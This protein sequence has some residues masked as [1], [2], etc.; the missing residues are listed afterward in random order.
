[1]QRESQT[2][3]ITEFLLDIRQEQTACLLCTSRCNFCM[4]HFAPADVNKTTPIY[5]QGVWS[6]H[7]IGGNMFGTALRKMS[8][9]LSGFY[10]GGNYRD[11]TSLN[12]YFFSLS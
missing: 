5:E 6:R 4:Y 3:S 10:Q 1:M 9:S 2:Q 11:G 12:E 7:T 8:F